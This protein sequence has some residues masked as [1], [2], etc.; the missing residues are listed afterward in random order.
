MSEETKKTDTILTLEN[1][2]IHFPV[3]H[4]KFVKAVDG[5]DLDIARGETLGLVGESG[6]GKSSLGRTIVGLNKPTSGMIYFKGQ[7]VDLGKKGVSA[8]L[9]RQIQFIFQDPA[10]SLNPRK[11]IKQILELP[12][13]VHGTLAGKAKDR[14][15]TELIELVGLSEHYLDRYPH[16]LSGGQKQRV[17]IARALA[18]DPEILICDEAV[19]ALDVSIQ[20]QILN[21]LKE[22]QKRMGLTYIFISHNLSVVYYLCGRIAVMYLGHIVELAES[23]RLF[24]EVAHPY[25]RAL[26]SAIPDSG[27]GQKR[28]ILSG[29]L[30]SPVDP[31]RGCCF[32]TRCPFAQDICREKQ[33]VLKE[34][35][36]HHRVACHLCF[37]E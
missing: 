33:P 27:T 2:K 19:S 24:T 28:I 31:P 3:K 14:R 35:G 37:P 36:E 5:V 16:E 11:R 6:C 25:T 4:R 12:F 8:V 20:A 18:L 34:L 32:H 13:I 15:I 22:L 23:V 10:A 29:E 9:K 1:L 7:P 30:P 17:G 26:L 21:L